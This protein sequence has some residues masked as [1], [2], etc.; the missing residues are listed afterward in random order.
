MDFHNCID[1]YWIQFTITFYTILL[2]VYCFFLLYSDFR[3][4]RGEVR[5]ELEAFRESTISYAYHVAV[6]YLL[7]FQCAIVA[8]FSEIVKDG[9]IL[10]LLIDSGS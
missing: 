6:S 7:I 4:V 8:I 9:D 10:F 1:C 5:V 2:F 3:F